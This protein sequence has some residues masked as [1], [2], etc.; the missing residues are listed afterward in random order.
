MAK[1][2]LEKIVNGL[3]GISWEEYNLEEDLTIDKYNLDIEAEK[4]P[5]LVAKWSLLL[6]R[7]S[8]EKD[9]EKENLGLVDAQLFER[10]GTE[11]EGKTTDPAIKSWVK[12]HPEHVRAV[13]KHIE[14]ESHY[15]HLWSAIKALDTKRESIAEE[16]RLWAKNYF[17]RPN[18]P[19]EAIDKSEKEL[20]ERSKDNIDKAMRERR[21]SPSNQENQILPKPKRRS[22]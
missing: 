9:K 13:R 5:L 22:I 21:E 19:K 4:M 1:D 3:R 7:A 15:N 6:A 16:S 20:R 2:N 10:A 8:K 14:A 18:I 12:M 17:S 11:K